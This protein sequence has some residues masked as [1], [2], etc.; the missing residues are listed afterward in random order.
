[1][2]A[3]ATLVVGVLFATLGAVLLA[4]DGQ[5]INGTPNVGRVDGIPAVYLAAYEQ[6][7]ARFELE[8]LGWSILAGIGEVESDHGQS[9]AAGVSSGQNFHGCCAG[10]MQIHNGFGAGT[11]TWGAYKVD[12]NGDGR[13]D[14]YDI[15]DAA[16]TA[17]RY[18]RASGAPSDWREALFAYNH[19]TSYVARVLEL[20]AQ[21]RAAAVPAAPPT[22]G[23]AVA[24]DGQWL[25]AVPGF[26]GERCDARIVADV[27]AITHEFGLRLSD[28]FGG[29][30]HDSDGEHP[31]G[32]AT[33]LV[34]VDGDW[35]RTARAAAAFGWTAACATAGCPGRGPLRVVLYNGYPGHGDPAHTSTPHLH[36]SWQHA[37]ARPFSRAA[38]VR[39]LIAR[40]TTSARP[41]AGRKEQ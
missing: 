20:A 15:A 32:L 29:A 5:D 18:L 34:P 14:I 36:L 4:S 39:V 19:D 35:S 2:L 16:P 17:A 12:G 37:A 41:R 40:P 7:A 22:E 21:Y 8:P 11:G 9:T 6:A 1:M 30:P 10:P 33:D 28:C 27:L 24:G 13:F 38:W 25:V 23:A 3:T 26:P 31:L